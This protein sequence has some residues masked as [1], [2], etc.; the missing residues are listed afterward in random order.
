V[1]R[2]GELIDS[3]LADLRDR[4]PGVRH[5]TAAQL[6]STISD[7]GYIVDFLAAALYVDDE[8][9]FA[10]FVEWLVAILVSRGVPA[11]AVALTLDHYGQSL[12]DFPRAGRFL[13]RARTRVDAPAGAPGR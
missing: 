8:S 13:G 10:E 7:L 3:A 2:R 1:K 4:V 6:D 9:L 5:Y 12:R 11:G